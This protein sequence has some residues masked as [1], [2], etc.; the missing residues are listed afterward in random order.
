MGFWGWEAQAI[1]KDFRRL[2][3]VQWVEGITAE[4]TGLGVAGCTITIGALLTI[5][6]TII[7]V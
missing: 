1:Q 4:P 5:T 2:G 7:T 3:L 6:Y